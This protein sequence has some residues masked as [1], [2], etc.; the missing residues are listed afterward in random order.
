MSR[1]ILK[2]VDKALEIL[3]R[4]GSSICLVGLLS[5]I[6]AVVF[7]RFVPIASLGWSDEIIEFAFAWMVFLCAAALWRER[8]HFRVEV[9]TGWLSGSKAG[10]VLEISLS[11]ISLVFLL[12]FTYEGALLA[13]KAT[14][15][16]P[17]FEYPRTLWYMVMPIAGAIMIGYT[18]R[19]LV[20]FFRG[21]PKN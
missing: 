5:L 12:V 9:V 6:S 21:C 11:L 14:D 15:R 1:E 4:W 20:G 3:L 13:M 18:I 17:I 7:V 10:R 19:D 16:S 8:T 2:K